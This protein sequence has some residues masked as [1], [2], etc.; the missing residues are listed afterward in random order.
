MSQS[1]FTGLNYSLAN[2]DTALELAV[3]PDGVGHVFCVAGSGGRAMPLLARRPHRLT[4]VDVSKPQLFLTELRVEAV[5][6]LSHQEYL[7]LWGYPPTAPTPERRRALFSRFA[8]S[9]PARAWLEEAFAARG[10]ASLLY[11]GKWERTFQKLAWMNRKL[12]GAAGLELF[13]AQTD[14]EHAAFMQTRF[15]KAAWSATIAILGNAGIFNSLLYKGS[16][17]KKNIEKSFHRFYSDCFEQLFSLGPARQ[18]FFL[19]LLFFGK[20]MFAEGCPVECDPAV[21]AQAKAALSA[22]EVVYVEGDLIAQARAAPV[23]IDFLSLSDV[24][25]YFTGALE[26]SF[27]R[28]VSANLAPGARVVLRSYIHVPEGLD[29]AGFNVVTSRYQEV[30]RREKVGVYLVDIFERDAA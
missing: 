5:R 21:F 24:P 2:E 28:D 9:N 20:V 17:P 4:C 27:L 22:T 1:Y 12:T 23:P 8:L 29:T 16:F 30:V 6:A 13:T 14:D 18:N 26:R 11:E 15:P 3:L 10:W 19:Q 7:E 25:S